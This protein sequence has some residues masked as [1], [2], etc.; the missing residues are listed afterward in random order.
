[1]VPDGLRDLANVVL[2]PHVSGLSERSISRM[3]RH[4]T[5]SVLRVLAHEPPPDSVVNPAALDH[6][7]HRLPAPTL[8]AP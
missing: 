2:T 6:P 5:D 4:A 3:T 7:R 8:A 1:V